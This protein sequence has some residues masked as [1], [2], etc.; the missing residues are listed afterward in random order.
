MLIYL[1]VS[2]NTCSHAPLIMKNNGY[3]EAEYASPP[4]LMENALQKLKGK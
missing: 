2:H 1:M 4:F 3:V